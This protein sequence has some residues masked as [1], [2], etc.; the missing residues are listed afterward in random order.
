MEVIIKWVLCIMHVIDCYSLCS[1]IHPSVYDYH[2]DS[3]YGTMGGLWKLSV[4]AGNI[5]LYKS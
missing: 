1:V 4:F 3:K 2:N 5:I